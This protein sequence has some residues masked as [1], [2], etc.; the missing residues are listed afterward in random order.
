[1]SKNAKIKLKVCHKDKM[2]K[3]INII[4]RF[5][6]WLNQNHIDIALYI[7]FFS[8]LIYAFRKKITLT[9]FF[10]L[11]F[12]ASFLGYGTFKAILHY[13]PGTPMGF[14]VIAISSVS[15][16]SY[17]IFDGVEALIK[18]MLDTLKKIVTDSAEII[19]TFFNNKINK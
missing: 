18:A 15:A 13:F 14:V 7:G 11:W 16:Y 17:L 9:N 4:D 12:M 6:T 8:A 19:K 1:M 10:K 5:Y 3:I 2:E